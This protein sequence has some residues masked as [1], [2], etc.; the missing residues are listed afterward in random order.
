[1]TNILYISL[2]LISLKL[3]PLSLLVF[4][5]VLVLFTF[6]L[7]NNYI[8]V[9]RIRN[10]KEQTQESRLLTEEALEISQNNVVR[11]DIRDQHIYTLYGDLYP[12]EGLALDEWKSRIHPDDLDITLSHFRAIL[13]G[14][15]KQADFIYRWNTAPKGDE[16][17]WLYLHDVTVA[18]YLPGMNRP[19]SI[20]S[21]LSDE[22]KQQQA[23]VNESELMDKYRIIF[24]NSIIGLS[25]YSPDGWL[26]DANQ[27]MRDICHFG[28]TKYNAHFSETNLFDDPPFRDCCD[29]NNLQE[30]WICTQSI[31]PECDIHDYLEIRLHPIRDN[32]G[33]LI[34]IAIATRNVTQE[35]ELYL[36]AKQNDID[37]QKANEL[38]MNYE[39]ELNYMMEACKMQPWRINFEKRTIEYYKGLNTISFSCSLEEMQQ[40]F[41]DQDDPVVK[42]LTRPEEYFSGP[43]NWTGRVH[44]V[45]THREGDVWVQINSIPEY[46][47][48]GH[49]TG[50]FGLWRDITSLMSKQEELKHETER[51]NDSARLK[52]VF[53]ANMTHEIRTPL[54]AI[55]GFTDLLSAVDDQESKQ[56]MV[57][58]I[59]NNC[60]M[61]IRLINDILLLSNADANAMELKPAEVDASKEF[62]DICQTLA[63]RVQEPGVEFI[64]DNPYSVCR[65]CLD[66]ARIN[67]VTTNFVT[68]AVKYTHQGHIKVG[69]RVQIRDEKGEVSN[70]GNGRQGFYLYCED[71]G[72]GIPKNQLKR[73]FERFVKLN[74]YIQGTG[75]GLS[76]CQVIIEKCGGKIGVD[77]EEGKGST[78]WFWIPVE[79]KELKNKM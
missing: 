31:I 22:T 67:Q 18:E 61:L 14:T 69:Y 9:R 49:Q 12:K 62:D 34:Y 45:F 25:F 43:V 28:D 42:I 71:T 74:D 13:K 19:I 4:F 3:S 48:H 41:I 11:F 64:A 23:M 66:S 63:Q 60:D 75:L 33:K 1:M 58:V 7:L 35:R 26:L 57:R 59:H 36:Q 51:A 47:E 72:T 2:F 17:R 53:L 39:V 55:V 78:F 6:M 32:E 15:A 50:C 37:I 46:D 79:I 30:L 21:T 44:S 38:I 40:Q 52:S 16:P 70:D 20:I 68:N 27:M 56:E 65:T 76:I 73:I 54:N 24:E 5:V 29:R 8:L 10:R 77:S